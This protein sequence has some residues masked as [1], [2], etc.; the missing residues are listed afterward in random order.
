MNKPLHDMTTRELE[1]EKSRL[2]ARADIAS[3][4][5]EYSTA[6]NGVDYIDAIL[7]ER[8]AAAVELALA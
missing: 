6:W 4:P 5:A 8:Q 3:N 2:L 7:G 1:A